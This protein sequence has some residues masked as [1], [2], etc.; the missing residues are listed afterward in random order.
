MW[1]F[2]GMGDSGDTT[3]FD[4]ARV[5]KDDP[6][7]ELIGAIDELNSFIGLGRSSINDEDLKTDLHF[8][9]SSLS[10][11]MGLIAGAT[12]QS[13][14]DF[15]L[16]NF[17]EWLESKIM[18]YSR[19]ILNPK[20]FTFPGISSTGAI[21]DICRTTTRRVERIA[22]GLSSQE[23]K[24]QGDVLIVLNRLSSYLYI[25]RLHLEN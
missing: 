20:E 11:M 5:K 1:F 7:L 21:L 12:E 9:Q 14:F 23:K 3:L 13:L 19:E 16:A 6:I 8:V 17:L 15:N 4:G 10:K 18:L 24:V 2:T 22:V 25:M